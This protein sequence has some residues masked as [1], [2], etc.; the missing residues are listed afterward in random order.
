MSLPGDSQREI[1]IR[2]EEE[3]E[4]E[5][6]AFLFNGKGNVGPSVGLLSA[7]ADGWTDQRWARARD[8]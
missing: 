4:E 8:K 1:K 6:A 2:R 3:E 5:E 7:A